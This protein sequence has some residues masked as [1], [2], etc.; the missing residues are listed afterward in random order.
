MDCPFYPQSNAI[1]TAHAEREEEW[2]D[3]KTHL[4]PFFRP[5]IKQYKHDH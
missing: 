3:S 2:I 4:V 5:Q 1:L